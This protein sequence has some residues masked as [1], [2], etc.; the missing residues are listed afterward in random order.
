[1]NLLRSSSLV[2]QSLDEIVETLQALHYTAYHP[3]EDQLDL[4][5]TLPPDEEGSFNTLMYALSLVSG[6]AARCI[7][8]LRALQLICGA[9]ILERIPCR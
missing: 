2:R 1:M 7:P 8:Q 5:Q 9:G 3:R 6:S 4:D